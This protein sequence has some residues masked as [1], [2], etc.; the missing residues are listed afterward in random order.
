MIRD[1]VVA[2]IVEA[3][4]LSVPEVVRTGS[5][6][7]RL[8]GR[9]LPRAELSTGDGSVA[10]T[11]YLAVRWPVRLDTLGARVRAR[12][13][14]EVT[15]LTGLRVTDLN[16]VVAGA[17]PG[18]GETPVDDEVPRTDPVRANTPR[19]VPAAVPA[20]IVTAIGALGLAFVCARELLIAH[21]RIGGA[22]WV[23][24]TVEWAS[25][26]HWSD[27]IIPAIVAAVALGLVLLAAA[28]KPRPRTHLALRTTPG[29]TPVVWTRPRDLARASSSLARSVAAVQTARTAVDRRHVTVTTHATG[30]PA[31]V[32]ATVR[33]AVAP[34]IAL[35]DDDRRVRIRTR[36]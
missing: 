27:W 30:D 3:A 16:V 5:S 36:P 8:T 11:L 6:L 14:D 2:H 31:D 22:P 26:L 32:D 35:L 19:A 7:T 18:L 12:V 17:A 4:A 13:V 9:D 23:R 25:R 28:L 29:E 34:V 10:V 1:R 20:A 24:N 15:R 33:T 21:D